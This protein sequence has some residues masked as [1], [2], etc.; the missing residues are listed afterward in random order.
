MMQKT[1]REIFSIIE[2]LV[3]RRKQGLDIGL[4]P[5]LTRLDRRL[6]AIRLRELA[7]MVESQQECFRVIGFEQAPR[8][9]IG[10]GT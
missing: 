1:D 3:S 2:G 4:S 5:T 10:V 7:T 6:V 8:E 9:L